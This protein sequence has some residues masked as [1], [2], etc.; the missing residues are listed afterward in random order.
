MKDKNFNDIF[1]SVKRI[2]KIVHLRR[3]AASPLDFLRRQ[4]QSGKP[5]ELSNKKEL[6]KCLF[7]NIKNLGLV[8]SPLI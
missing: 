2:S 8:L 6:T 1:G 4:H 3:Y 7:L 5:S